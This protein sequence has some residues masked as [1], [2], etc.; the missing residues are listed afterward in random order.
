[1]CSYT[2]EKQTKWPAV[3]AVMQP[4]MTSIK[5]SAVTSIK[6]SMNSSYQTKCCV[7]SHSSIFRF[8]FLGLRER[9]L[10]LQSGQMGAFLWICW[11]HDKQAWGAEG[12]QN[13]CDLTSVQT[14]M[15]VCVHV[16]SM[17]YIL[18]CHLLLIRVGSINRTTYNIV[19]SA[20]VLEQNFKLQWS[21]QSSQYVT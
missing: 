2:C 4:A 16:K 6:R 7:L 11:W 14:W 5:W 3:T 21:G 17:T 9:L 19:H 13:W 12:K 20:V 8:G 18:C 1:M 10:A 15:W